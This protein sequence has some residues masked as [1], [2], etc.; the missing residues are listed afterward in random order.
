MNKIWIVVF[1]LIGVLVFSR[2]RARRSTRKKVLPKAGPRV[3]GSQMVAFVHPRM[4]AACLF[5]H[6]TQFGSGFRRKE[7]PA[8]PHD[9]ACRCESQ[10]FNFSSGE[11]FDGALRR[12]GLVK[13][14]IPGLDAE[15]ITTLVE[16]LKLV[17]GASLQGEAA[18]YIEAVD[19]GLFPAAHQE[20][21][22]DFLSER[23]DY[24]KEQGNQNKRGTEHPM[25]DTAG[26]ST[27]DDK[28][29]A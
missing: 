18:G 16:R 24:L 5:D 26:E 12:A 8:L 10:P 6:G 15:A 1:I 19:P 27:T 2:L 17:E 20:A 29:T 7:G 3:V 11:V 25:P 21:L 22:R 23:Y 4:A 13:G 28:E 9:E 14:S